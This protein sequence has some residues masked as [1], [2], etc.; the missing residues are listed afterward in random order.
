MQIPRTLIGI[1]VYNEQRYVSRVLDQVRRYADEI[2]VID[3]GSTDE[4][5]MLLARQPVEVIR[6]AEN[7][8]Y[9]RSMQ[10]M[11]RWAT[12]DGFDWL[13]TMDCD[14]QHEPAAIPR[15]LERIRHNQSDVISGSRYLMRTP[16][17]DAP[18]GDRRLINRT[19]T[20]EL[21]ARLDLGITDAFCGFKAYRVEAVERLSLDVDGYEFPMQFWVQCVA[22]GLAMEEIPVR[23]IYNDPSR[24]FGGPLDEPTTR[25]DHYRRVM[26]RELQ[27][28]EDRLDVAALAG[29]DVCTSCRAQGCTL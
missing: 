15:F 12:V 10:D 18:P 13:I 21:N 5:P 14:E 8:G 11:I 16:L 4:T 24:S 6:H 27:R 7:R 29:L 2:L 3:D 23:L 26:H 25:L 9:G 28:C 22:A 20:D 19:I 1:P 17:D